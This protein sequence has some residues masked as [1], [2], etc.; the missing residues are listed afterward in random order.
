VIE[1]EFAAGSRV[2]ITAARK[3]PKPHFAERGLTR[4]GHADMRRITADD[5]EQPN[6]SRWQRASGLRHAAGS[7]KKREFERHPLLLSRADDV[8]E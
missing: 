2:R 7:P 4:S 1:V 5:A 3:G 8:I 6:G